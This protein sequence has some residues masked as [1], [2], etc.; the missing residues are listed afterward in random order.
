MICLSLWPPFQTCLTLDYF[1]YP[2]PQLNY[3]LIKNILCF[4][5]LL[6]PLLTHSSFPL[7]QRSIFPCCFLHA[8]NCH[9]TD[10]CLLLLYYFIS[11]S[12]TPTALLMGSLSDEMS[13]RVQNSWPVLI[14]GWTFCESYFMPTDLTE[15]SSE[16]FSLINSTH[17]YFHIVVT[18]WWVSSHFYHVT[19]V[20]I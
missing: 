14:S 15:S 1:L 10:S 8:E 18:F 20:R 9:I 11:I 12:F 2:Q 4:F 13:Q 19:S 3:I 7:Y 6:Q 16:K 5:Y 17:H